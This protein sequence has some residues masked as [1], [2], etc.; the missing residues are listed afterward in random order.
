M[1]NDKTKC[2]H[3]GRDLNIA[4]CQFKGCASR[5]A[6]YT[7]RTGKL[8]CDMHHDEFA[9]IWQKIIDEKWKPVG[10]E[11]ENLLKGLLK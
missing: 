4:K 1:N 5:D 8:L 9:K 7:A 6:Y 10:T 3:C 11:I 2:R